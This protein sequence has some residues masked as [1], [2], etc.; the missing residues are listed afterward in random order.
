M[1]DHYFWADNVKLAQV[2]ERGGS[3]LQCIRGPFSSGDLNGSYYAG[4]L[5]G[6]KVIYRYIHNEIQQLPRAA[7][8][9]TQ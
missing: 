7:N 3:T 6:Q 1:H 5:E 2:S 4:G 8:R 9:T